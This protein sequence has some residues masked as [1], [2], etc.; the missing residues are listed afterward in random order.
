M[1]TVERLV[2]LGRTTLPSRAG[3][4]RGA[5]LAI[6]STSESACAMKLALLLGL[7]A[8][9]SLSERRRGVRTQATASPCRRY[10]RYDLPVACAASRL[11]SAPDQP[12]QRFR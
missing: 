1:H 3:R 9:T 4:V 2:V 12:A 10:H 11:P 6:M 8:S 7:S 5:S